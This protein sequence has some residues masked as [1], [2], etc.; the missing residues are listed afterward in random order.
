MASILKSGERM[1]GKMHEHVTCKVSTT[2]AQPNPILP[3]HK[4]IAHIKMHDNTVIMQ[5]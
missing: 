3:K 4:E 5:M 2:W 1:H